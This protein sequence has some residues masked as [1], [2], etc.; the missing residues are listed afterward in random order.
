MCSLKTNKM[1]QKLAGTYLEY[2]NEIFNIREEVT[3]ENSK[4]EKLY[5]DVEELF[6]AFIHGSD[7]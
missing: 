2:L 5:N 6:N 3:S 1:I 4:K 7:T